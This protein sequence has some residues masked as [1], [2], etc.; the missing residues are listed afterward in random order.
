M[1]PR[2][3]HLRRIVNE[4]ERLIL[5]FKNRVAIL[6]FLP[7]EGGLKIELQIAS[8][9]DFTD[10]FDGS[11][12]LSSR[13]EIATVLED[14]VRNLHASLG[15][16]LGDRRRRNILKDLLSKKG[17]IEKRLKIFLNDESN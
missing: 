17:A 7:R 12:E 3:A 11:L 16:S 15:R 5:R 14:L 13:G 1:N 2:F 8:L 4:N 9:L 10:K 6:N